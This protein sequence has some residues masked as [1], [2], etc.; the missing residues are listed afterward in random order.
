MLQLKHTLEVDTDSFPI[1]I[2]SILVW[3]ESKMNDEEAEIDN[4]Y[5]N[6]D[7]SNLK[8]NTCLKTILHSILTRTGT[9]RYDAFSTRTLKRIIWEIGC[10]C[11]INCYN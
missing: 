7:N 4:S 2:C 10:V 6:I 8:D 5:S 11:T 3:N 9:G 1:K